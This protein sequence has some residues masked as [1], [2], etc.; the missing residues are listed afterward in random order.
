MNRRIYAVVDGGPPFAFLPGMSEQAAVP[1]GSRGRITAVR[2]SVIEVEFAD[3][4]PNLYE[5]VRVCADGATTILEVAYHLDAHTVR[6]IAMSHT[7]GLARGMTVEATGQPTMVPVGLPTL[8]RLFNALGQPLDG[9]PAPVDTQRWPIHR[10][11]PA[12]VQQTRGL[13]FLETGSKSLIFWRRWP[14]AARLG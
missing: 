10:P 8:G 11:A 14:V 3:A 5:A 1:I 6:A 7:E 4:L 12:L 2:G 9:Q 13:E